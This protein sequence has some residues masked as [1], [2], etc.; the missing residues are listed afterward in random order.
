M[1]PPVT[2]PQTPQRRRK[3]RKHAEP[4]LMI[5]WKLKQKKIKNKIKMSTV[6]V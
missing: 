3:E 1:N 4:K 2:P 5:L 6:S